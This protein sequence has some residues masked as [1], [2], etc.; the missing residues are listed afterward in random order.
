MRLLTVCVVLL[1]CFILVFAGFSDGVVGD[2]PGDFYR[3][4]ALIIAIGYGL[5]A[6]FRKR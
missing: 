3:F 1:V 4:I 5:F 2:G 6:F